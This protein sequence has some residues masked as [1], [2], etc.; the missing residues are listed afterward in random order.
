MIGK[1]FQVYLED[2]FYDSMVGK[3]VFE[4]DKTYLIEFKLNNF[5]GGPHRVMFFKDQVV[6]Y[7]P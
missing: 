7:S 6:Q 1:S 3:V 4:T 2:N 5:L